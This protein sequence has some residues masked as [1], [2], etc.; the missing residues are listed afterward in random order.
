ME[1]W[2]IVTNCLLMTGIFR[3]MRYTLFLTT[4]HYPLPNA[5]FLRLT[6]ANCQLP[7]ADFLRL[8]PKN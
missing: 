2:K 3:F 1:K 8:M 4:A 6:P 7:A 5:D